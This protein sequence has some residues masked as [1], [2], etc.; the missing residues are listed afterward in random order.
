MKEL[1]N[2]EIIE[3]DCTCGIFKV[4]QFKHDGYT[5]LSYYVFAFSA[6]QDNLWKKTRRRLEMIWS[7]ITG[8]EYQLYEV[9]IS[10]NEDLNR[11]KEFV[12]NMREIEEIKDEQVPEL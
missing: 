1:V 5:I 10:S 2:Q 4:Q 8:K 11:F 6:Y 7:I 3:C 12:A 9:I